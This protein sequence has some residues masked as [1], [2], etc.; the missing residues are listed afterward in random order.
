MEQTPIDLTGLPNVQV[1]FRNITFR[2][3][4]FGFHL[5][6]TERMF[7][8]LRQFYIILCDVDLS[9]AVMRSHR[10]VDAPLG[11]MVMRNLG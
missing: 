8:I 3:I 10:R 11:K 7:L 2:N 4:S 6:S 5:R 1:K 9:E